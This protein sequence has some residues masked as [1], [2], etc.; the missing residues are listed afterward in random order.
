MG[1]IEN[2]W[3]RGASR[4]QALAQLAGMVAGSALLQSQ[5]DPFRDHSRIPGIDELRNTVDF[6]PV[7]FAKLPRSEYDN[8][9]LGAES[10]FTLRRNREAFDWVEIIP[11]AVVDVS[12]VDASTEVLGIKLT[13]PLFVAP[14]GSQGALH[15]E[16]EMG[17]HRGA[18]AAANTP[19]IVS[20]AMSFPMD[21]IGKAA[22]GPLWFQLYAAETAD[23]NRDVVSKAVD[24]GA[25][26]VAVTVDVQYD[27]LRERVEHDRNLVATSKGAGGGRRARAKRA[28]GQ[29]IPYRVIPHHPWVAWSILDQLRTIT[30]VPLLLK[31]I[32]T[33]EDAK[34]AVEHGADGIIV[35][36]HGGRYLDYAPATLEALPEIV[37]AVRGRIPVL[38][39]GGFRRGSDVFKALAI[40]AKAVC[41]GRA[42]R[43]GL[44][45]YGPA[46]AQRILEIVQNELLLAMAQA[47]RPTLASINRSAIKTE[48]L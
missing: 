25:K 12:K 35:S 1:K 29:E 44:A 41:L 11:Q 16:G 10:E 37:D 45:A 4:R 21:E 43:W 46:G 42:P 23:E 31:G 20:N 27:S 30:K 34:L 19:M 2:G 33:A 40:G 18:T 8:S 36:N 17:M 32:L 3:R 15:P 13:Y 24:A 47:G 48:F 39:D 38:V 7:A 5:Q 6:E 9:S 28:A 26:A 14:S 22:T